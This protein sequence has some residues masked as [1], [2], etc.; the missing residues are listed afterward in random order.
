MGEIKKADCISVENAVK[1][2]GVTRSTIESYIRAFN[3]EKRRFTLDKR[4]YIT[5]DDFERIRQ[6][7]KDNRGG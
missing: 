6:L 4:V 2:A 1:E 3:V 5:K 7:I